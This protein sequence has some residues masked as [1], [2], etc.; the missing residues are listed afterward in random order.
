MTTKKLKYWSK[1]STADS[2]LLQL[3]YNSRTDR[4]PP[5]NQIG[6]SQS[7][8][9]PYRVIKTTAIAAKTQ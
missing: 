5:V 7:R 6:N 8:Q 2:Y 3:T 4:F 1:I 9:Q